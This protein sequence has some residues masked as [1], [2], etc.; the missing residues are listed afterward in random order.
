MTCRLQIDEL[1]MH[2]S[3]GHAQVNFI[4][5]LNENECMIHQKQ[6]SFLVLQGS[7]IEVSQTGV[8]IFQ[9][10]FLSVCGWGAR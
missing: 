3:Q 2:D 6:R 8:A 10:I 9:C 5:Q 7:N 1:V 4:N